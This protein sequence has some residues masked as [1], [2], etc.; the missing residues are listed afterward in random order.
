MLLEENKSLA[1]CI[2]NRELVDKINKSEFEIL[3]FEFNKIEQ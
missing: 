1:E 2:E 3:V